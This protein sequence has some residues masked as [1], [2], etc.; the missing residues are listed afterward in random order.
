MKNV[1]YF[2][3]ASILYTKLKK[4]YCPR[5]SEKLGLGYNVE[6]V[7]WRSVEAKKYHFTSP[8]TIGEIEVRN[9]IFICP[10]CGCKIT[11]DDMK[12][13]EKAEKKRK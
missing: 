7:N 8:Y 12:A 13:I 5:C 11:F 9:Q 1:H 3:D 4:H 10:K 6:V 2:F